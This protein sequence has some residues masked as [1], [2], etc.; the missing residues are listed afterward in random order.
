[1]TRTNLQRNVAIFRALN[2]VFSQKPE[3]GALPMLYA[4]TAPEAE[5]GD[6]FGPDG[7]LGWKGYPKK[8]ESSED[9]HN[10]EDAKKLWKISEK[11]TGIVLNI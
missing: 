2:N 8:V 5:G 11:L 7:R 6:Y 3:M 10:M 9:S 4:A 1:W